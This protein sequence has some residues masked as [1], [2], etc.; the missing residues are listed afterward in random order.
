MSVQYSDDL[1][2]REGRQ[3]YFDANGFDDKG[4]T[5]RWVKLPVGPIS[6]YLLNL[7]ARQKVIARHDVHHVVTGYATD[8]TG[9][10]T[11]SG[12]EMAGGCGRYWFGWM[13]NSQGL[14]L[15][16]IV[17]PRA[18]FRGW[19]RGWH[20]KTL[21]TGGRE[22]DDELLAKTVGQVRA[23]LALDR[24]VPKP[25]PGD[26][27]RFALASLA[28][29]IVNGTLFAAPFVLAWGICGWLT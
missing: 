15:G 3:R 14:V 24:P 26:R 29:L 21:Y 17:N 22:V 9:E 12:Y 27:V 5:E 18:T 19:L 23:E 2:V 1:T 28:A 11:I 8:W 10:V 25:T 13:V 16:L 4:Y 6:I 20:A 7:K